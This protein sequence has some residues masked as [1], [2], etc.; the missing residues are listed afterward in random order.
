MKRMIASVLANSPASYPGI[1]NHRHNKTQDTAGK[2]AGFDLADYP[3]GGSDRLVGQ[4]NG[5]QG[6]N[7]CPWPVPMGRRTRIGFL[8]G[9]AF[10]T[11]FRDDS[12]SVVR[13]STLGSFRPIW[14]KGGIR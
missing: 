12:K 6:N 14:K 2:T 4:G 7:K 1:T 10:G 11:M 5:P 9:M 13:G 8:R 3:T